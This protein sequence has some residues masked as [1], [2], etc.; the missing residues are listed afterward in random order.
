MIDKTKDASEPPLDWRVGRHYMHSITSPDKL[1][2][3]KWTYVTEERDVVLM[4]TSGGYAMVRRKG[5]F[6]YVCNLSELSLIPTVAEM[7]KLLTP[8]VELKGCALLRSP[9]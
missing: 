7:R 3:G 1:K 4:A 6:P 8:N 5:C 2:A 9:A